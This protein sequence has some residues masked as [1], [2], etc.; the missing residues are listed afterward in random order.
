MVRT[1]R[2]T[3]AIAFLTIVLLVG[4]NPRLA[5]A[6]TI[7]NPNTWPLIPIPEI[8]TDPYAG[9]MVGLMT[10]FLNINKSSQIQSIIA[11][12]VNYNTIL[13]PGG[14]M[15]YLAY[16]S[17]DTQYYII[18]SGSQD[19]AYSLEADYATGMSRLKRFS[20]EGHFRFERDPTWRFFGLGNNSH[21]HN[22]TNFAMEQLYA[23]VILGY[24][25]TP[26]LQLAIR[27]KPRYVRIH[28]GA[29]NT[30]PF[31]GT[32][33]P[34]VKGLNGGSELLNEIIASY[35]T[36]N[37]L[38]IPTNGGL[39]SLAAGA[40]DRSLF[41]SSSYSEFV[42]N[43]RH[44]F[45]IG[46]GYTLAGQ[47]YTRYVPAGSETPFWAMSWLGGDGPGE[48]SL[49]GI[50]VSYK[51]TWRGAGTGRYIDND[52]FVA[53]VELRT[54]VFHAELFN[55]HGILELAPFFDLGRVYHDAAADPF[56]QMHPAGGIGFRAIAL[57][58]VVAYVDVGYGPEG[59]NVFSGINYPF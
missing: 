4:A 20:F 43:V 47:L 2:R 58:F 12:D 16:P 24:N 54:R 18:G 13:G 21:L 33:F 28:R 41:S 6:F 26:H 46:K 39:I 32:L 1:A 23:D 38:E 8:V 42:A 44:Y 9:T 37:S 17:A 50:P 5:A 52:M 22:Q 7:T 36:R 45:P 40:A 59:T 34:T 56:T 51:E 30:L 55:T 15:R 31:I 10:V 29:L 48:S 53:N 35:D 3:A 14:T 19:D 57:P 49:L 25:F 11:P 27:E